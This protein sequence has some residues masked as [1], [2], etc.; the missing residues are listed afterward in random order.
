M[1]RIGDA[2]DSSIASPTT[3]QRHLYDS[4][5]IPKH[6]CLEPLDASIRDSDAENDYLAGTISSGEVYGA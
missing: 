4:R 3:N 2:I 1:V 5:I 6:H